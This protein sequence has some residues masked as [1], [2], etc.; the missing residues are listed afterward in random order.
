MSNV[1]FKIRFILYE[2]KENEIDPLSLKSQ[3]E[4]GRLGSIKR[5]CC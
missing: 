2:I 4:C 1:N 3:K 5:I